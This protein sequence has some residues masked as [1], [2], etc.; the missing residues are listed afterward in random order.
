MDVDKSSPTPKR[1]DEDSITVVPRENTADPSANMSR[2]E[3]SE[4]MLVQRANLTSI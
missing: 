2:R 4:G 3:S 1:P